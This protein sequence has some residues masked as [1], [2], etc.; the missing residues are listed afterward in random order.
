M[1]PL[2]S[3]AY[4]SFEED[5]LSHGGAIASAEPPVDVRAQLVRHVLVLLGWSLLFAGLQVHTLALLLVPLGLG[6]L[7]AGRRADLFLSAVDRWPTVLADVLALVAAAAVG[8][9]SGDALR[10]VVAWA[11]PVIALFRTLALRVPERLLAPAALLVA[12]AAWGTG[13]VPAV[14]DGALAALIA[15]AAPTLLRFLPR[16]PR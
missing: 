2:L 13:R 9:A 4:S 7:P 16:P 11:I 1:A 12:A 14:G 6:A 8:W 3:S 15:L 10:P 5:E